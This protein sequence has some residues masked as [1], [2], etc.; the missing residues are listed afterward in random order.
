MAA[1]NTLAGDQL[2]FG[3]AVTGLA[4]ENQAC[5]LAESIRS[6]CGRYANAPI[7]IFA[8]TGLYDLSDDALS[9]LGRLG[10]RPLDFT[11]D[12]DWQGIPFASKVAASATAE[13][14]AI[15]RGLLVWL[16]P[17][18]IF[19][20]EPGGLLLDTDKVL[21]CRPV[22]HKL[23]GSAADQPLDPFW[24]DVFRMCDVPQASLFTMTT[25]TGEIPIRPYI[26]AGCLVVRPEKG[27]LRA[28]AERF[29]QALASGIF[30]RYFRADFLY[31]IF[32]HQAILSGVV[33]SKLRQEQ[34]QILDHL[35]NYPIHMHYQYPAARRPARMNELISGRYEKFFDD[36]DWPASFPADEPLLSWLAGRLAANGL[37]PG[38]KE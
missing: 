33:L 25:S 22:D 27:L 11:L 5:L 28:W 3:C 6:N 32:L 30:E 17:H 1:S 36:P 9:T 34:I 7:W 35:V 19:F 15:G 37:A 13:A 23:I 16:D 26:N 31:R 12:P 14:L 18:T 21:G 8:P 29:G 20:Q 38:P 10:V 2:I 4:G 24:R